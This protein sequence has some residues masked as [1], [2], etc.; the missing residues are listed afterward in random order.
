M[1][2]SLCLV[3]F[4]LLSTYGIYRGSIERETHEISFLSF[5]FDHISRYSSL[6][7]CEWLVCIDN[8]AVCTPV[9]QGSYIKLTVIL[10]FFPSSLCLCLF[11]P[12]FLV[13]PHRQQ[14]KQSVLFFFFFPTTYQHQGHHVQQHQPDQEPWS[15][16]LC[17]CN[18]RHLR[19]QWSP[20]RL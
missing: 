5:Y 6:S 3:F 19:H 20:L 17:I 12:I 14:A 9:I 10:F 8:L 13:P 2:S 11:A 18:S 16:A 7:R 15:Q 4:F 1:L